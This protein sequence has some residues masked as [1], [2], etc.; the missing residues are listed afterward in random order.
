MNIVFVSGSA[1]PNSRAHALQILNTYHALARRGDVSVWLL[2]TTVRASEDE[3]WAKGELAP[4]PN[5]R[6]VPLVPWWWYQRLRLRGEL[7]GKSTKRIGRWWARRTLARVLAEASRGGERPVVVTRKQQVPAY[8]GD[9]FAKHRALVLCEAHKV[10]YHDQVSK[11]L[12]RGTPAEKRLHALVARARSERAAELA[13]LASFDGVICTTHTLRDRLAEAGLAKPMAVIPNGVNLDLA[14]KEAAAERDIEIL[15]VGQLYPWK[16]V[17]RLI[18]AMR[19]LPGRRLTVV[20]GNME[21]DLGRAQEVARREGVADRIDFLG[22]QPHPK[23]WEYLRRA[24]VG[25]VPL[26]RRHFPE[27]RFFTNPIK[28]FEMAAAETP[29]VASDLPSI[30]EA[31]RHGETAWLVRPDSAEALAEGI[32]RLLGDPALAGRLASN[33][34]AGVANATYATRAQRI[35][36]FVKQLGA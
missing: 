21:E 2:P 29:I 4:L 30:R 10:D 27:A 35:V 12:E 6:L 7:L 1:V 20:G 19:H 13:R 17:D 33:A 8:A 16:G 3:V 18:E 5:L 26:P 32:G 36:D 28:V 25:V 31:L 9:L 11:V 22:H 15:Y 34:R 23:V 14:R 24:R